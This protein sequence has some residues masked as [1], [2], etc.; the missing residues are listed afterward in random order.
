MPRFN[1][2]MFELCFFYRL[3]SRRGGACLWLICSFS[4]GASTAQEAILNFHQ[5]TTTEGLSETTNEFLYTDQNNIT[6]ISALNGVNRFDGKVVEVFGPGA[7]G[8]RQLKVGDV[9]S[10]F[11]E[12]DKGDIW[13]T[14]SEAINFFECESGR[15]HSVN[16][17]GEEEPAGVLPYAFHL[18]KKRYLWVRSSG[19]L[20]RIDTHHPRVDCRAPILE[21]FSTIR[22]AVETDSEGRV[23][24]I[25][26]GHWVARPLGIEVIELDWKNG[27]QLKRR[28]AFFREPGKPVDFTL[29]VSQIIS[30]IGDET[31][32]LTNKGLLFFNPDKPFNEKQDLFPYPSG[33]NIT[34]EYPY[35]FMAKIGDQLFLAGNSDKLAV[36]H[37][38][39]TERGFSETTIRGF[40]LDTKSFFTSINRVFMGR[41]SII[42]IG[43]GGKGVFYA[44]LK[45]QGM[46]SVFPKNKIAETKISHLFEYP[47]GQVL[48]VSQKGKAWVFDENG[49]KTAE[50]KALLAK[51]Y[52]GRFKQVQ[53]SNGQIWAISKL[54]LGA[55]DTQQKQFIWDP[56]SRT[57]S[58]LFDL[59]PYQDRY[60]IMAA[61]NSLQ[62]Y[63]IKKDQYQYFPDAGFQVCLLL[64]HDNRLWSADGNGL[65]SVWKIAQGTFQLGKTAQF[66]KLG[67]IN[68]LVEDRYRGQILVATSQ[69]LHCISKNLKE[70]DLISAKDGLINQ[71]VQSVQLDGKHNIWLANNKGIVR[72]VPEAPTN[73]FTHFSTRDGLSANEYSGGVSLLAK[74]GKLWFGSSK[75]TD[76]ISPDRPLLG[77]APE[78]GIK[79]LK[80]HGKERFFQP[81]IDQQRQITLKHQENTLTFVLEAPE[82]T[83]PLRNKIKAFLHH[84]DG[85]DSI[86]IENGN[87]VTYT[88]LRHGTYLFRFTACNAEGIWQPNHQELK[89]TLTPP[90]Y[91]TTWFLALMSL[92]ALSIA[93]SVPTFMYKYRLRAKQLQLEK[94]ERL[95]ERKQLE[96]E[97]QQAL[98]AEREQINAEFH[99]IL[100]EGL[101]T[102]KN[103]GKRAKSL[104][105]SKELAA[106]I[107]IIHEKTLDL[108]DKK[109]QL[110]WAI[111]P[112]NG[113]LE[114]LVVHIRF[115]T[116]KLLNDNNLPAIIDIPEDIPEQ[117]ISSKAKYNLF[118]TVKELLHNILKYAEATQVKL[119]MAL[120]QNQFRIMIKD[121]GKG[122][123]F[124]TKLNN[125]AQS[126]G[127]HKCMEWI[128]ALNGRIRWHHPEEGG[129]EVNI[130]LR[131]EELS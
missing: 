54:G 15:I 11:F 127:L 5:L 13:F 117:P 110:I 6:W 81:A 118:M 120:G 39:P 10:P 57:Q 116:A 7:E 69:G 53:L 78:L 103:A 55:F 101:I 76:L 35:P 88:Y 85:I 36:F 96:L 27:Y 102:I 99:S 86:L 100:N 106:S 58:S 20:Y 75:G 74:N 94:Q 17:A 129:T 4:L 29:G 89:I 12:N 83:D 77:K 113:F 62:V 126:Y 121:N 61:L 48:A 24:R 42:W 114:D 122:F 130:T 112:E 19:Q 9:Q 46:L 95:T 64:D 8:R 25:F 124:E 41:D 23:K 59:I 65:L 128:K 109:K 49:Q 38:S 14:T 18:E 1:V 72:Y 45:N 80:I 70:V 60:L 43:A 73:S 91:L 44:N 67:I 63:D 107:D 98:Q 30:N 71:Y 79:A 93:I 111:N 50:E 108:F 33:L 3:F 2:Q 104:P 40:N 28:Q 97:K 131:V 52:P 115:Y 47:N 105:K 68:Q 84:K 56:A 22:S 37:L 87:T 119:D 92:L 66:E 16:A 26:S 51:E 123:D 34:E 125:R 21:A 32:F 82:Y 31:C 90:F